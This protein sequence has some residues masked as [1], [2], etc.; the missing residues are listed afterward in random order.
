MTPVIR[1]EVEADVDAVRA[2]IAAAFK[3]MPFSRQTEAAI[4]DALRRS[5]D[6]TVSLVAAEAGEVIGHVAL[7][8]VTIGGRTL[9][10]FG[11]G[12]VAVRPDRQRRGVGSALIREALQR[13]ASEGAQG[14][15]LLG[16]PAYYRRFGFRAYP[17]L[18]L[19]NVPPDHFLALPFG[20]AMPSGEVRYSAAFAVT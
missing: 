3:D 13:L 11:L 12:P 19:A 15:V 16:E 2:V 8:P 7:S 1:D 20:A 10:W 4:V 6:L 17:G 14:C 5:G 18:H 9:G